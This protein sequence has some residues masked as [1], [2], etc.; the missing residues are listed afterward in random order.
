MRVRKIVWAQGKEHTCYIVH[1][2]CHTRVSDIA[3]NQTAETLLTCRVPELESNSSVVKVHG[4]YGLDISTLL[5]LHLRPDIR[6]GLTFDKKSMPIVAWYVLSKV[7]YIKRVI[8]EVL[9]TVQWKR[10]TLAI[11]NKT[12]RQDICVPLCSPRKTSLFVLLVP[13]WCGC[14]YCRKLT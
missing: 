4:L 9:P 10:T 8:R 13:A 3:W 2:Y 5:F 12:S 14:L 6:K 7:S 1:D 11:K